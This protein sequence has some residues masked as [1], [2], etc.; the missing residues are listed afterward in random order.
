MKKTVLYLSSLFLLGAVVFYFSN[1]TTTPNIPEPTNG[2]KYRNDQDESNP[3]RREEWMELI[4]K[5]APDV[6]WREM[7]RQAA[8]ALS[9]TRNYTAPSPNNRAVEIFANGVL[10]GEWFERG[11]N[12]QAGNLRTVKYIPET[13]KIYGIATGGSLWRGNLDGSEW[14]VLNDNF[15]LHPEILEAF[16]PKDSSDTR[17]IGASGKYIIHSDDEGQSWED[18]DFS[19][20]FYDTWGSPKD[21]RVLADSSNTIYYLAHTWDATPWAP[22]SWLYRSTDDGKN[23][24]R[25]KIFDLEEKHRVSMWSPYKSEEVYILEGGAMLH[26]FNADTTYSLPING[27]N[28]SGNIHLT[29]YKNDSTL[30][31]YALEDRNQVYKSNNGTDWEFLSELPANAWEVG[32]VCSPFDSL[33]LFSG[34]VNCHQSSDGGYTWGPVNEWWEYYDDLDL[35]HADIMDF[36]FYEKMDSTPFFLVANHGGLNVSYDHFASSKNI[37]L[38]GLNI[39]EYYD[40]VTNQNDPDF[41]YVGSQDQ[42]WQYTSEGTEQMP[43]DF[44]QQ[45]GGDYGQQ[46]LTGNYEHYW[47]Q[48]P[49]GIIDYYHYATNPPTPWPESEYDVVGSD[50]PAVNWIV[51]TANLEGVPELNAIFVAGGNINEGEGSHLIM[52]TASE[53][54]PFNLS[55]VQFDYDF[56]T[57]SN[58]GEGLISAIEQ[59]TFFNGER[60]Y[61]ATDDGSFFRSD[62]FAGTWEKSPGFSGPT[63]SWIY[64]ACVL[65]SKIDP[66]VVYVSGSGYSNPAVFKSTDAGMTFEPISNGLPNTLVQEIVAN[67]DES[68]LFAATTLGPFV[69]VT[70]EDQWYPLLGEST[71]LQ[72]FSSVEYIFSEDVVRYSTMGRG[73]WDLKVTYT[74]EPPVSVFENNKKAEINVYP[75]P[76]ASN[77]VLNIKTDIIGDAGFILSDINGRPVKR[78]AFNQNAEINMD[79]LPAGNYFYSIY[80]KGKIMGTGKIAVF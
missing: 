3:N 65:A 42:G 11:S 33:Q 70:W 55:P 56:K 51:P 72:W 6:D 57:N 62:D 23:F 25:L 29:G 80:S 69:Y 63:V 24:E 37:G 20:D 43:V 68:L 52:L 78:M 40:V 17:F 36:K 67:P 35:L 49:G 27:L 4:H 58:S 75:S 74:E 22:R 12:N 2:K 31:L 77:G 44:V 21:I 13:N 46:L 38:E 32:F 61:I 15:L 8:I 18:A 76:V 7:D 28:N 39:G 14:T 34:A 50:M 16:Y 79:G 30:V 66:D 71:P 73:V 59:S 60:I 47:T 53:V 26:Y 64:T 9:R 10:E 5:A 54:P 1:N 45:W 41:M 48:Y 19:P